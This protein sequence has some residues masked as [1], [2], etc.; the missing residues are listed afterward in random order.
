MYHSI[1]TNGYIFS[2]AQCIAKQTNNMKH[3]VSFLVPA[4][5]TQNTFTCTCCIHH[6]IP[7]LFCLTK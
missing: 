3:V 5:N 4:E 6:E 1:H 2:K 7:T